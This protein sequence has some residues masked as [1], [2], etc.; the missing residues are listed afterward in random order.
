MR[1]LGL[2]RFGWVVIVV[3]YIGRLLRYLMTDILVGDRYIGIVLIPT[4]IGVGILSQIAH[5]SDRVRP[6]IIITRH[7]LL[8]L[9]MSSD[10]RVFVVQ[11]ASFVVQLRLQLFELGGHVLL[12]LSPDVITR[13]RIEIRASL[14][15]IS[16]WVDVIVVHLRGSVPALRHGSCFAL[17]AV[18][19]LFLQNIDLFVRTDLNVG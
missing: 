14:G 10:A 5:L 7:V 15:H 12:H 13:A 2:A 17:L 3:F 6:I 1:E 16:C 18:N 9:R 11:V 4:R 19:A 8:G